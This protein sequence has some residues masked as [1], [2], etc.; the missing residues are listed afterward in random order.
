M[1]GAEHLLAGRQRALK[2]R[3]RRRI[4][5]S[6][7]EIA[8]GAVQKVGALR[9]RSGV[10]HFRVAAREEVRR[11]RRAAQPRGRTVVAVLRKDRYEPCD[12]ALD[13]MLR[14]G[15]GIRSSSRQG[16]HEAMHRNRRR[17]VLER[18]M[19]NKRHF[20]ESGERR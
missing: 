7:M 12:Q 11:Q 6:A 19:L 15:L 20:G 16:L 13:G 2:E 8:A 4:G 1:L 9:A 5:G 18:I 3:L 10:R 14:G 17:A